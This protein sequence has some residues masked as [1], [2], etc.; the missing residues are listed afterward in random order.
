[1]IS[2]EEDQRRSQCQDETTD[3]WEWVVELVYQQQDDEE[4]VRWQ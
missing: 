2:M 1:M 3:G 4:F